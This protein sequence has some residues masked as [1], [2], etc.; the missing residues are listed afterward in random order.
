MVLGQVCANG[1]LAVRAQ[2][3][4]GMIGRALLIGLA[5]HSRRHQ[6]GMTGT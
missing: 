1:S 5:F 4:W 6:S 3:A 2:N